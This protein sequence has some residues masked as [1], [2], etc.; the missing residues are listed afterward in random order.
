VKDIASLAMFPQ[1][2]I[3]QQYQSRECVE[4]KSRNKF[5]LLV[6]DDAF[7]PLFIDWAMESKMSELLMFLFEN[8]SFRF[9]VETSLQ[10]EPLRI[11]AV[12]HQL[13]RV[14]T[15]HEYESRMHIIKELISYGIVMPAA[16]ACLCSFVW[17]DFLDRGQRIHRSSVWRSFR[18]KIVEHV[19]I[20]FDTVI[21][22][23]H[24][25]VYFNQFL[26]Q[27][28]GDTACLSCWRDIRHV[29]TALDQ[30]KKRDHETRESPHQ[31]LLHSSTSKS[32]GSLDDSNMDPYEPLDILLECM[33]KVHGVVIRGV[34][35]GPSQSTKIKLA[36]S[37]QKTT[38]IRHV[39]SVDKA[40]ARDCCSS[41]ESLLFALQTECHSHLRG[42]YESFCES[43]EYHALVASVR[44]AK[45]A[46]VQDYLRNNAFLQDVSITT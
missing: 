16:F 11:D 26:T 30:L 46:A 28:K 31:S 12:T 40:F 20:G 36:E 18:K 4:L 35:T 25:Y 38:S 7:F 2:E 10:M 24:H 15:N 32:T 3:L 34:C 22:D 14:Y 45:S 21:G 6:L 5:P 33:R 17:K 41:L 9:Q 1:F 43:K 19:D 29:T 39:K 27:T 8:D 42:M 44:L 23:D 13:N 37:F